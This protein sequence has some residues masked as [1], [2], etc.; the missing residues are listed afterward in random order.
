MNPAKKAWQGEMFTVSN[1]SA[2]TF[3][4]FV[5]FNIED[6]WHIPQIML[7][8][9][10]ERKFSEHYVSGKDSRGRDIKRYRLSREFAIEIM[11][12]LT[13]KELNDLKIKQ[14]MAGTV[15]KD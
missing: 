13:M 3:K 14:S 6:G 9:L 4:K 15:G 5:P 7:N 2:G 11:D 8:F 12:P 10:Q 1:S